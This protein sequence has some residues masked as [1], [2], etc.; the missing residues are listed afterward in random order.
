MINHAVPL[1]AAV[2]VPGVHQDQ[3]EVFRDDAVKNVYFFC[4]DLVGT[5]HISIRTQHIVFIRVLVV[6]VSVNI[7]RLG[8]GRKQV[9]RAGDHVQGASG[10]I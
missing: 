2:V 3:P 8:R 4:R 10:V 7:C 6:D 5:V 9:F 1:G